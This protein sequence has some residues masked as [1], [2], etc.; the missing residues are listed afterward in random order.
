MAEQVDRDDSLCFCSDALLYTFDA[1]LECF[2]VD[3][4]EYWNAAHSHDAFGWGD[5]RKIGNDDFVVWLKPKGGK[6]YRDG[7]C[8]AAAGDGVICARVFCKFSFQCFDYRPSDV[9]TA[10]EDFLFCL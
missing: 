6:G 3:I 4:S 7:V 2:C 1:D 10:V 9:T 8:S 5:E